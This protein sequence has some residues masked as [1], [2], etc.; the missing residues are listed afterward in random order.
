MIPVSSLLLV[1][2]VHVISL[3]TDRRQDYCFPFLFPVA[4]GHTYLWTSS[5]VFHLP[6]VTPLFS[7]LLTVFLKPSHRP[8]AGLLLPLP[9][10]SRPW[11]HIS[12]D[13]ITG[14][15]PSQGN[16]TILTIIDRFSKAAHF[17]PLPKLPSS[18]ETADLLTTHIV[19]Q[20][21]IPVDIV[22]DRGPQFTSRVWRN[23]CKGIGAKELEAA[24]AS[25]RTHIKRCHQVWKAARAS[26]IRSSERMCRSANQRRIPAPS[27]SP[28]QQVLLR[29]K[30]LHLE[31]KPV[32][33]SPLSSPDP[34]PPPRILDNGDPVWT[35]KDILGVRR[36]GRG[37]V[38]LV[39]WEGYGPEHRSWVPASYLADPSLLEDFYRANPGALRRSS[40]VSHKGGHCH[41][42]STVRSSLICGSTQQLHSEYVQTRPHTRCADRTHTRCA[43]RTHMPPQ[44]ETIINQ[45]TWQ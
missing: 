29:A 2:L 34:T 38:Y 21:G 6:K 32:T 31:I 36:Q 23:F 39:D 1:A 35:V 19:R 24:V 30:D 5:L 8:P 41:D 18:A 3:P 25:S 37:L 4:L 28:G 33:T 22:S 10:P 44:L 43:D 9:V 40:G 13:F 11:S 15:P 20:H 17:I 12:L 16:T 7:P 26:L 42:T 45:D 27:Y 14:F